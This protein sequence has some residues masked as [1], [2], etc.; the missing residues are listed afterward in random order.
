MNVVS[1]SQPSL[2]LGVGSHAQV[3]SHSEASCTARVFTF[4]GLLGPGFALVVVFSQALHPL[5][6]PA[7]LTPLWC[8]PLSIQNGSATPSLPPVWLRAPQV[9]HIR[10]LGKPMGFTPVAKPFQCGLA[11]KGILLTLYFTPRVCCPSFLP[12]QAFKLHGFALLGIAKGWPSPRSRPDMQLAHRTQA[13][14]WACST[15]RLVP[16]PVRL[17]QPNKSISSQ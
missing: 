6:L 1:F 8:V 17:M 10:E 3:L 5:P 7:R 9:Y 15:R 14:F 2:A 12:L 13:D 11:L 16:C 4:L